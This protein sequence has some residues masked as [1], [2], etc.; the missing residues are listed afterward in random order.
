MGNRR[1]FPFSGIWACT[2]PTSCRN[3][4]GLGYISG[5]W[6]FLLLVL[7]SRFAISVSFGCPL[8]CCICRHLPGNLL[9]P[10]CS[11][12]SLL[13]PEGMFLDQTSPKNF[14]DM[15]RAYQNHI[16]SILSKLWS[17]FLLICGLVVSAF[18][19]IC[20]CDWFYMGFTVASRAA[21]CIGQYFKHS[22]PG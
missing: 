3:K 5:A 1:Q 4:P 6:V 17:C 2:Y 12:Q 10:Y 18:Y 21:L 8:S 14:T 22:P 20:W 7:C 16:N 13:G 15:L 19:S 9:G 11:A